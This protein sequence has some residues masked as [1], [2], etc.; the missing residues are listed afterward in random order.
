MNVAA[1]QSFTAPIALKGK[2]EPANLD[3]EIAIL[4]GIL[5]DPLAYDRV[6]DIAAAR[7]F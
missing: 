3:I 7:Q 1:E 5:A 6:S 2:A 4:G